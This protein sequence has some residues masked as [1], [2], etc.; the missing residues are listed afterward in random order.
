[1]NVVLIGMKHC[2]KSTIG[3]ALAARWKCPFYDVDE[4][5]ESTHACETEQVQTVRQIFAGHGEKHFHRIEGHAVCELYL[6]LDRP[7]S[8]AV[9]SLG[10]RTALN[11]TINALLQPIGLVVYLRV[12]PDELY[13]RIERS[14]RPAFLDPAEPRDH[15][16]RLCREREP[17]YE[18]LANLV[19]DLGHLGVEQAVDLLERRIR[20]HDPIS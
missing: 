5:I 12:P 9:V 13:A 10:G 2:G 15:F 4:L 18:Q 1:M 8:N 14:G 11:S 17:Q 19:I 6:K 20:E 3:R 7:G 16:F